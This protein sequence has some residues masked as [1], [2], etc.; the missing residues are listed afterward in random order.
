MANG[1]RFGVVGESGREKALVLCLEQSARVSQ[2]MCISVDADV[3]NYALA[4]KIDLV[5]IGPE[6]PL[7]DGIVDRLK[8]AGINAF[9]PSKFA[10]E[11][12]GSKIFMKTRCQ[13]WGVPTADFDFAGAY[14]V[15]E[16]SIKRTGFRIIKADGLCD[17]K[18]V[19]VTKSEEE[20][21]AAAGQLLKRD[22]VVIEDKLVGVECSIMAFC[23]GVHARMLPPVRDEKRLRA[24]SD[25]MTGGMGAFSPLSDVNE[26]MLA[27]IQTEILNKLVQ[28]MA[29]EGRPYHGILYAGIMLTAEGPML[30]EVNC[31]FGNP[32]AQVILPRL[33]SDWVPYLLACTKLG[34]LS[35]LPP[36]Q[37]KSE[38][39][40]CVCYATKGY[41]AV[42]HR[43][44]D[45]VGF[46]LTVALAYE[47]A[48]R[49]LALIPGI[50]DMEWRD[51]IAAG[52]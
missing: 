47:D 48:Y 31:R 43:L 32:E 51:D 52:V 34:G 8:K 28:G 36:L 46:G 11:L 29:S 42:G 24:G 20:A 3:V 15:A 37:W 45:V 40:V 27:R 6:A 13:R 17:G 9:G 10:A 26:E 1:L 19:F 44:G 30:L 33:K 38:V 12:E 41:P 2:V 49:K 22:K 39:A 23:D 21:L 18:G 25:I 5:V 14:K 7:V 35:G 16:Q 50:E 4:K